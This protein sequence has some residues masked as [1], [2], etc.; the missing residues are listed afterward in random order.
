[1]FLLMDLLVLKN[2]L[3]Y[4]VLGKKIKEIKAKN[5]QQKIDLRTIKEGIYFIVINRPNH[6]KKLFKIIKN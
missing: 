6:T 4:N 1:M 3:V 5:S 2:I